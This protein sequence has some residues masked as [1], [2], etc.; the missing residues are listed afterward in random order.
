MLRAQAI[1]QVNENQARMKLPTFR[2]ARG[3]VGRWRRRLRRRVLEPVLVGH[4]TFR[5]TVLNALAARGHLVYCRLGDAAFYVDPSDRAVG[6]QLMWRGHWQREEIERAIALLV[7]AGRLPAGA[8]FV[9][10]GANIGTQTVYA[11]QSGRFARAVAFEPEPRNAALLRMNLAANG[12]TERVVVVEKAVGERAGAAMLHLHPRNK[13]H[14]TIGAP[15]S[16]DGVEQIEVAVVRLDAALADAG[17]AADAIG[18]VWIDVEGYEPEAIRGLGAL[19]ERAVPLALEY[20]PERLSR[21]VSREFL[22][23][24]RRHYK[25]LHNLSAPHDTGQ[26][27]EA[28]ATIRDAADVLIY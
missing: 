22:A 25:T 26:P 27:I 10:A 3:A 23:L 20:I 2:E 5:E 4:G 9:D 13:G 1:T 17:V 28:L 15:P 24:L 8:V 21:E 6:T 11:M 12:L 19:L 16:Y 14:H 7:Q 18:L